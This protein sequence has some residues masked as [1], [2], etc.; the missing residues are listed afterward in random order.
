MCIYIYIY[1]Y[2]YIYI[3]IYLY[4][5]MYIWL[6]PI[7]ACKV[8]RGKWALLTEGGENLCADHPLGP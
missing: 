6:R 1:L 5:Y 7:N 4:V 3:Y 8:L 2:V